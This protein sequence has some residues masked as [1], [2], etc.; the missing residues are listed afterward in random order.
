MKKVILSIW[1]LAF[2][3]FPLAAQDATPVPISKPVHGKYVFSGDQRANPVGAV[4]GVMDTFTGNW[5]AIYPNGRRGFSEPIWDRTGRYLAYS[6]DFN[7]TATLDTS[8]G[9]MQIF[10]SIPDRDDVFFPLDWSG[11]RT[12]IL[13]LGL[14]LFPAPRYRLEILDLETGNLVP[15]FDFTEGTPLD[16]L[17]SLPPN[18]TNITFLS[19]NN[20]RWNPV[21][22]EWIMFQIIG[23]Q[24]DKNG[25]YLSE[26]DINGIYNY[27]TGETLL[28][29]PFFPNGITTFTGWSSEGT[30]VAVNSDGIGI[31]NF[32]NNGA[33]WQINLDEYV[34]DTQYY[35][36]L[37]WLDV[38]DLLLTGT[39]NSEAQ[40]HNI[41]Q[42]INGNWYSTEFFRFPENTFAI[43]GDYAWIFTGADSER[44]KLSCLFDQTLPARLP[45]GLRGRVTF[46]D[47]TASRL[48]SAP[49]TSASV[50]T[51]MPEGTSFEVIGEPEC[52]DG[53][54]WLQLRLADGTVGYAAEADTQEYFL[55]PLIDLPTATS[56]TIPA[57][58]I[59]TLVPPTLMPTPNAP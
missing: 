42:V 53:Y 21:Y 30:K 17:F 50:V 14:S 24:E 37:D 46:T 51:Q 12:K 34:K 10:G 32:Y 16:G 23:Q 13:Q 3:L 39:S 9:E 25:E 40:I 11:D 49:G 19:I 27:V 18:I 4:L 15:I 55:E 35:V 31:I 47:G 58:A 8:T 20:A 36:A 26:F 5:S 45:V 56:T 2:T 22:P 7:L 29:D 6:V 44:R 33:N 38:G 41:S 43:T 54:R 1:L 48:R 57:T 52:I 28:L 59:F